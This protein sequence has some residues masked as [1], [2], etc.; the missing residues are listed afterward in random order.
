MRFRRE[1]RGERIKREVERGLKLREERVNQ[2]TQEKIRLF[3][4]KVF[5]RF[6]RK[7]YDRNPGRYSGIEKAI[8]KSRIPVSV[9]RFMAIAQFY[10]LLSIIP[11]AMLGYLFGRV[12]LPIEAFDYFGI[13]IRIYY[14]FS[15]YPEFYLA[16]SIVLFSLFAYFFIR[17][18]IL[19]YPYY[20]SNLRKG[21]IESALPHTVNMLLGMA[22]GG[23]QLSAAFKFIAENRH[24]FDEMSKEFGKI[25]EL[26]EIF[27][28]DMA[29][30][31]RYVQQ[32]TP[33]DRFYNFLDNFLNV[34]ESGGD[35]VEYLKLKSEQLLEERE[36]YH[37][38]FFE[39]LQLIAE[40]YLAMF[41]VT[42]LF[43]LTVLVVFQILQGGVLTGFK[44][45][46][47]TLLPVG[48]IMIIYMVLSMMPKEPK[49]SF[50]REE[51][52][53]EDL[54]VRVNG[55]EG[56]EFKVKKYRRA[57]NRFK[58]FLLLPFR[59]VVYSLTIRAVSLYLVIP[60]LVFFTL[61]YGRIDLESVL[62][63][64]IIALFLP[65]I[66]FVEY[67][68][69][70]IRSVENQIPDF[71]RQLAGLNEAGLNVV[72]ALRYVTTME[73]G[74]LNKEI[75]KVKR[76]V[77]WG[78]L[79]TE[80]LRKLETRVRSGVVSRVVSLVV[81]AIEST[82]SIRDALYTAS[83][84]S[85][86]EIEA[87]DRIRGQMSMYTIIIYIAFFVF[88]YTTYVLLN[89]IISI[90][91]SIENL[92][93]GII[94]GVDFTTLR[95]TFYQTT[96]MVG[97]FSGLTAGVMGEG[98]IESGLKHVI[99]FVLLGYIFFTKIIVF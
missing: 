73:I 41:I 51:R 52:V 21:K 86:M 11:G 60:P 27:G 95:D 71:L 66:F 3:V 55:A 80:A 15:Q 83:I 24:I 79:V 33:S 26:M 50:V 4:P 84:Y 58:S 40:I 35:V 99:V 32:T 12:I 98:K 45:A 53:I 88:L 13:P 20:M 6:Y 39:T 68:E 29:T 10:A 89:N 62:I 47:F 1:K 19:S 36:K 76:D 14:P 2:L 87:K 91:H 61:S 74:T 17:N 64:T 85:E 7:R 82:P 8:E 49:A 22:R 16:L 18:S 48:S 77:E 34:V 67:R 75:T 42:P 43:F 31:M 93:P 37:S 92:P 90:F 70:V 44:I 63:G 94:A 25:V 81:K 69:R 96:L 23:V 72:E 28:E 38:L 65:L 46:L 97:F 30:A 78:E 59:E 54:G 56:G 57:L 9:P 5:I